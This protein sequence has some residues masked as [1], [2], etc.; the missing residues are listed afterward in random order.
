MHTTS[1]QDSGPWKRW[2]SSPP[3]QAEPL[4]VYAKAIDKTTVGNLKP[5]RWTT[6]ADLQILGHAWGHWAWTRVFFFSM[7]AV[8]YCLRVGDL[9]SICWAYISSPQFFTF[10]DERCNRRLT[11]FPLSPYLETWREHV[12]TLRLPHHHDFTS[13]FP[14][15]LCR[16]RRH[17]H[18]HLPP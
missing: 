5:Q 7:L 17:S 10:W 8:V 16:R 1:F 15:R 9:E 3:H 11:S 13:V 14:G 18:W 2:D 6:A 12:C 4:W